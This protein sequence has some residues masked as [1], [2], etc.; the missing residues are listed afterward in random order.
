MNVRELKQC[1]KVGV[2]ILIS[3]IF[4]KQNLPTWTMDIDDDLI[5]D[6]SDSDIVDPNVG[7]HHGDS[8]HAPSAPQATTSV[9]AEMASTEYSFLQES[10]VTPQ[11]RCSCM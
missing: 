3:L 4:Q 5:R 11:A 1:P 2:M 8:T 9:L 6:L 10:V 7:G